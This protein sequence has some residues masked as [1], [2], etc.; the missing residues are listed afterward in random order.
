MQA[1]ESQ[2]QNFHCIG[3]NIRNCIVGSHL[4][5]HV[6]SKEEGKNWCIRHLD[7][8]IQFEFLTPVKSEAKFLLTDFHKNLPL[9]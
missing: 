4:A 1:N 6:E 7:L 8:R 9:V 2:V 3:E 5:N